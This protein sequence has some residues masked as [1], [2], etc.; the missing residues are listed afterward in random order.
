MQKKTRSLP[1]VH[2]TL[3]TLLISLA[4][5]ALAHE[6]RTSTSPKDG[7]TVQ[8]SPAKIGIEFG[9]VMRITQ[10]EVTGPN[11]SVPLDGQPG[12]EQVERY[13]VKPGEVLSA[14]NYQVRWRGLSDDGHMMSDGFNFSIEP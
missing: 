1:I 4:I 5:P 14:G 2:A 7:D 3:A 12:S 10:F 11:G 9:D 8:D 13:F 6:G